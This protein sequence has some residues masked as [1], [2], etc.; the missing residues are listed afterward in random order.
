MIRWVGRGKYVIPKFYPDGSHDDGMDDAKLEAAL[1][2]EL[3]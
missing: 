2:R 1:I 3:D